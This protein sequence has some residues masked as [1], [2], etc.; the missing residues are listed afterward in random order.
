MKALNWSAD[1]SRAVLRAMRTVATVDGSMPLDSVGEEMLEATRDH[2]LHHD[3]MLDTLENITPEELAERLEGTQLRERALQ[4]L[5][6][7]SYLPLE[8]DRDE[9]HVVDEFASALGVSTDMLRDL[10][11]VRDHRLK[12][13]AFDYV[14]RGLKAFLPHD[15]TW[16]RIRR[17]VSAMHQYVGDPVV[18]ARY[19]ALEKLEE[20]TL[21]RGFFHFYR[22]RDFPLPGEKGGFSELF[23]SHDMTHVLAGFN[24]DMDGEMN[25]A[26]FQAGMS[27]SDY[28]WEML[29]EIILDY[30]L[31]LKFTTAGLV[32]PGRGHFHPEQA[33]RGYERGLRC[34]VDLIADWD[35]W[36]VV[37][38]PV[39]ELRRRYNIDGVTTWRIPAPTSQAVTRGDDKQNG[40]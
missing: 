27:R 19:Q 36:S 38:M 17:I 40:G 10:H 16:K 14:R 21:G 3:V 31:G 25:V 5:V 15:S 33:L 24:T 9:V 18:A 32:E 13:L 1:E 35:Y 30:H 28:G 12:W 7:T 37:D 11:R 22:D 23:V 2:V 39:D 26:A 4:F 29:M 8:L 20:G 6:L 34:N